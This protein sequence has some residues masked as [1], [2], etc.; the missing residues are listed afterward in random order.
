MRPCSRRSRVHILTASATTTHQ[1]DNFT[2]TGRSPDCSSSQAIRRRNHPVE[3]RGDPTREREKQHSAGRLS[4]RCIGATR[5][6]HGKSPSVLRGRC[7]ARRLNRHLAIRP[8][9]TAFAAHR[10]RPRRPISRPRQPNGRSTARWQVC[11]PFAFAL[12]RV[13]VYLVCATEP[14]THS[15]EIPAGH[16]FEAERW[17]LPDGAERRSVQAASSLHVT[18]NPAVPTAAHG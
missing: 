18:S 15:G 16:G 5:A 14:P 8:R 13:A 7:R 11:K 12:A 9:G 6:G 3:I 1:K 17:W 10:S 2:G 4:L